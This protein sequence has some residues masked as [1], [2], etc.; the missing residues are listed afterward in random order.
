[1]ED[2]PHDEDCLHVIY[3][4][5]GRR[6]VYMKKILI[7]LIIGLIISLFYFFD[8][9]YLFEKNIQDRL[10]TEERQGD[11]RIKILAIDDE[12][13]NE[14][15]RWPWS[16][17][18]IANAAEELLEAGASAV[19]LDLVFSEPSQN[20]LE[21][22]KIQYLIEAYD[23]FYLSSYFN[24]IAM[25][26]EAQGLEYTSYQEPIFEMP[27]DQIG[28][29]NV[30]QDPDRVVRKSILGIPKEDGEMV[31]AIS[32]R[33]AN[34]LLSKDNKITYDN[35]VNQWYY[36][37]D[38]VQTNARH[39]VIFSYASNPVDSSFDVFSIK[40]LLTN[41]I[42][43]SSFKN[44][45]VLIG[46]YTVGLQ[47]QYLTPMSRTIPMN[48]VEIHA[49]I[50]QSLTEGQIFEELP[51]MGGLLLV[52][53]LSAVGYLSMQ[54]LRSKYL[55][56]IT[57]GLF[58]VYIIVFLFLF[59][60]FQ[61]VL[62]LFYPLLAII[63]IYIAA[64]VTHFIEEQLDKKR[65]TNIFGRYVSK[66]IVEGLIEVKDEIT[67]SGERKDVT[68]MFIDMRGFTALS[69]K[70]EPEEVVDVLNEY[71][72]LCSQAIFKY[73]GTID[74]FMGDGI[75]VIF[76]APVTQKDHALRAVKTALTMQERG[77]I[78]TER[79]TE[80]YGRTVAFGIGINSGPAVVGNIGSQERLD[81]TAIGDTVNLA[82]RLESN[83]KPKQILIS[84][85]TYHFVKEEVSCK[86]LEPIMVK[87]KEKPVN[88]YEVVMENE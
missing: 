77:K 17:D 56:L 32:V 50:I 19:W 39:E 70:M 13:L 7:G 14:I 61:I 69:E 86:A 81:Y 3:I 47:D 2:S 79:L 64:V 23:H 72:D 8:T 87:G 53:G 71:L 25:Q 49:N 20:T 26:E 35:S 84:S 67:I 85:T 55:I 29:I 78:W 68:L 48:G 74:K 6:A 52:M 40:D 11:L 44:S 4:R 45:I 28:H 46:P 41:T 9:F 36:G 16:R 21:D 22:E 80:K 30:F 43:A 54:R 38:K 88:I 82:A 24:F 59:N 83:A 18:I 66:N 65:I 5:C 10:T 58:I 62:P 42:P 60:Q 34:L 63:S 15:G 27:I 12:S 75:M 37:K 57:L 76:G 33:L 31:P 73:E 51:I 1:M